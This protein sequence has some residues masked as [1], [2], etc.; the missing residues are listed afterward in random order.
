M[1]PHFPV[2]QKHAK[3]PA[4]RVQETLLGKQDGAST[5]IS[6]HVHEM[7]KC[8]SDSGRDGRRKGNWADES[9]GMKRDREIYIQGNP[10]PIILDRGNYARREEESYGGSKG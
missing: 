10:G 6:A 7:G 3:S 1:N 2:F 5:G 9:M 4:D 8:M